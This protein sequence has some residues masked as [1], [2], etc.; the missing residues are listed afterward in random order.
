M[1]T[2]FYVLGLLIVFALNPTYAQV[3]IGTTTPDTKAQLDV[4]STNKGILIP[5]LTLAQRNAITSPTTSLLIYQTDNTPGF[6]YYSGVTWEKLALTSAL[7]DGDWNVSGVNMNNTNTGSVLIGTT[8]S[9]NYKLSVNGF[10]NAINIGST[11]NNQDAFTINKNNQNGNAL[12]VNQNSSYNS[13]DKSAIST[14]N[15]LEGH[16]V[17]IAH[18]SNTNSLNASIYAKS[19]ARQDNSHGFFYETVPSLG[20]TGDYYGTRVKMNHNG[21]N[22]NI[23]GFHSNIQGTGNSQKYGLYSKIETTAGSTHYG[24]YSE[25]LKSTGYAGYFLGKVSIGTTTT[26]NYKLPS[27]RGTSGQIMRTDGSGNVTWIDTSTAITH[28]INDLTDG[29]TDPGNT[30]VFLGTFSGFSDDLSSNRNTGL[31]FNSLGR[32][33]SGEANTA[34]GYLA[35]HRNLT[36]HHNTAVGHQAAFNNVSGSYNTAIGSSALNR[37]TGSQNTAVGFSA[38]SKNTNAGYNTALG[39]QSLFYNTTG[40][41]NTA[42]GYQSLFFNTNGI[43]NVAYGKWALSRNT[44]GRYNTALGTNALYTNTSASGNTA[45]GYN[46]L[47]RNAQGNN[48]AIGISSG[49]NNTGNANVFIGAYS[50]LSSTGNNKLYIENTSASPTTALIYGE[51][52]NNSSTAGN[53]LRTNSTFQIGNP[54]GTGYTFPTSRGTNGQVLKTNGTGNLSWSDTD[55]NFTMVSTHRLSS[56]NLPAANA[57]QS[58]PFTHEAFDTNNEFNTATSRFTTSTSG[59][60]QIN[61]LVSSLNTNLASAPHYFSLALF[62]NNSRF[63]EDFSTTASSGFLTRQVSRLVHLNAGEYLEVRFN[64]Y[65]QSI[66]FYPGFQKTY[67][68]IHRVR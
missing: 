10:L 24:V 12:V 20:F 51:F 6:Y 9:N 64:N 21:A 55:A 14:Y 23:Y 35:I 16:K 4:T 45:V 7:D 57:W 56:F 33:T 2:I 25:V 52:G 49:H 32:N 67:F 48:T 39:N 37:N 30:S 27:T 66:S 1:K 46:A 41:S 40:G 8:T 42:T 34:I 63:I 31:G 15:A 61:I 59:Y 62:K 47:Y 54:A 53:I 43:N 22:G 17:E 19:L 26:N 5:R 38:L 3:G 44:A 29:K 60:Y 36:G 11:D 50:G 28:R 65:N 68:T 18:F 13:T 58:I